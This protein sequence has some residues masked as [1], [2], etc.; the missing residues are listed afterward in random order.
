M[1]Q[2][3]IF[4]SAVAG[5]NPGSSGY[6]TV[7][8][9][10]TMRDAVVARLE[11]WSIYTHD[12]EHKNP[13]I[14]IYRVLNLRGTVFHVLTRIVDSGLDYTG[15]TN[16]LAHHLVIQPHE[17]HGA[18]SPAE[19]LLQWPGWM[20]Q[21][22]GKPQY[23]DDGG[24]SLHSVSRS[25]QMPATTWAE[26]AGDAGA[27]T[28]LVSESG[29]SALAR[30]ADI[31]VPS[32][33]E[34]GLLR[35][36]AESLH[37][38]DPK[39]ENAPATWAVPFTTFLQSQDDPGDFR[40]RGLVPN[41][42]MR[43]G[44][45]L[46]VDFATGVIPP[47]G[48]SSLVD[49]ARTGA[50]KT[51]YLPGVNVKEFMSGMSVAQQPVS[52]PT[53]SIGTRTRSSSARR[54]RRAEIVDEP[55]MR[56]VGLPIWMWLVL[57]CVIILGVAV[58]WLIS[59]A[60]NNVA[61]A[62]PTPT[63]SPNL[64]P[65]NASSAPTESQGTGPA[66]PLHTDSM[67]V[68]AGATVAQLQE[69]LNRM[70]EDLKSE[71]VPKG[72]DDLTSKTSNA[73][74]ILSALKETQNLDQKIID[75]EKE[76]IDGLI[77]QIKKANHVVAD[78]NETLK[79]LP[80]GTVY[81][82]SPSTNV[83]E[84]REPNNPL[85]L[86]IDDNIA[87]KKGAKN[88]YRV[89]FQSSSRNASEGLFDLQYNDSEEKLNCDFFSCQKKG[90]TVLMNWKESVGAA[91]ISFVSQEPDRATD[92]HVLITGKEPI[93]SIR[94]PVTSIPTEDPDIIR[95]KEPVAQLLSDRLLSWKNSNGQALKFCLL[96]QLANAFEPLDSQTGLMF[97][98]KRIREGWLQQQTDL[99][100]RINQLRGGTESPDQQSNGMMNAKADIQALQLS[101]QAR[102]AVSNSSSLSDLRP[103]DGKAVYDKIGDWIRDVC[104]DHG[105]SEY[106]LKSNAPA[107]E[108]ALR[109]NNAA[110]E[111]DAVANK[112]TDPKK[113]NMKALANDLRR[114]E[115][116]KF[117]QFLSS[118][119]VN[120]V[121]IPQRKDELSQAEERLLTV[122]KSLDNANP[123][124]IRKLWI[125]AFLNE[126]T[127]ANS[128]TKIIDLAIPTEKDANVNTLSSAQKP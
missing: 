28:L 9:S 94:Q 60:S 25:T 4:T 103:F 83:I 42:R 68:S 44:G 91:L 31:I 114:V 110:K 52:V 85:A 34:E 43:V 86:W 33:F 79:E 74:S 61:A 35:L 39:G 51:A 21:W 17:I 57:L 46:L 53:F 87:N 2:Q 32:G 88:R 77:D 30:S 49:Y 63:V 50:R 19:V 20:G 96:V 80:T 22:E 1:A 118:D 23:I 65:S 73:L 112:H 47:V 76:K 70:A 109:L 106:I 128:P 99:S 14:G 18:C 71:H 90:Q 8:R 113:S 100:S 38:A 84:L 16:F 59:R 92:F 89:K 67:S 5:L 10:E 56:W 6:C 36:Y 104:N 93:L 115:W 27:A 62:T 41:S 72:S 64:P 121:K 125:G 15:R 119:L 3:L 69:Q 12:A 122:Q 117:D 98:F 107:D 81:V 37:L 55:S 102:K 105:E 124:K 116:K 126:P 108:R 13:V 29:D 111:L 82:V 58:G 26:W 7:A 45:D 40:W 97:D 95:L 54:E 48:P 127:A 75:A 78:A 66:E 120:P 123:T 11:Q 101:E 24:F